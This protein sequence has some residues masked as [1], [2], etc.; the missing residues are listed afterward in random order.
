MK[1]GMQLLFAIVVT[2]LGALNGCA[3]NP[4]TGK[5]DFV[6][7]SEAQEVALGR[8]YHAQVIKQYGRYEDKA[9]QAYVRRIG[10]KLAAHSHRKNLIYR[11]TVLDS[12]AIN[13]FA[14]PGGYIY[15]NRGLLA[16]LDSEAELA[17]VLAHEIGHVTARHSVRQYTAAV[18]TGLLGAI[19]AA[20]TGTQAASDLSRALGAAIV[21]GYGREHELEADRLGAEYLAR[22]GYDPEA[23]IAV[24]RVL[25]AQEEYEK[26]LAREEHRK[27]NVY[28]GVFATHP[29]N[30][31]R[32]Q[33]VVAAA[34]AQQVSQP[35]TGRETFL[36][37]IDQLVFGDSPR[38]GVV[39]GNHFYHEDLDFTLDFPPGWRIIN[40]ATQL[41]A[42]APGGDA[43]LQLAATDRN[44]R[45]PPGEFLRKRLNV[46]DVHDGRPLRVHDLEAYTAW[47]QMKGPWGYRDTR[48]TVI[49]HGDKAFILLGAAKN[50]TARAG[51][52]TAYQRTLASFR[53]MTGD[54]HEKAR[55]RRIHLYQAQAGDRYETLAARC[56]FSDHPVDRL[57]LINQAY[58]DGE[59]TPGEMIKLVY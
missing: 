58:P 20:R 13:A 56:L 7:M 28:H 1:N 5:T 19:I 35:A 27:P 55:P 23:M 57:R 41:I 30:D 29:D 49:Y 25:K 22:S 15:V 3:V 44:L 26:K 50:S 34:R 10:R 9:L 51:M 18:T 42:R 8:K 54:D 53:P 48:V 32:L 45:I 36:R 14:L 38:E 59:P 40:S 6:L 11:F 46:S 16:Y 17:A 39:R 4:A 21:R 37:A 33:T 2:G 24:I 12:K 47:G 52:E 43:L 31:K